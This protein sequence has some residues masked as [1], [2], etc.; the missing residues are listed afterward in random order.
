VEGSILGAKTDL[1]DR[2]ARLSV[3]GMKLC[4]RF[5]A[6][7]VMS[8]SKVQVTSNQSG[9]S[10]LGLTRLFSSLPTSVSKTATKAYFKTNAYLKLGANGT[11]SDQSLV[12]Q[13]EMKVK[14]LPALSDN[15]MYLIIDETSGE[16]AVVDP[17][18]PTTV[19]EAVKSSG[20]SLKSVLTTHHHWDH[21]GGNVKLNQLMPGLEFY[22]GDDRIDAL[23][24]KVGQGKKL[25]V[26]SLK[27]ECLFT[28]CHTQGHICYYVTHQDGSNP[29]VFTGDTLFLGGCGRFFEGTAEEMQEALN[30]TLAAL[31]GDTLVYCGHE[32]AIQNLKF[33]H[34]VE[35]DNKDITKALEEVKELR[36]ENKPS[37]PS[38]ISREKLINPFMRVSEASVKAAVNGTQYTDVE[39][40]RAVR[41]LKD[42][43]KP[44]K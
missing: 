16:A 7:Y 36:S 11:H 10:S 18:E 4:L 8:R 6:S 2:N 1:T 21:S 40:M 19:L 28:P 12:Q 29:A 32:Y 30:V 25:N 42:N 17:V 31:P 43:F 23:T 44:P 41:S 38:T 20:C 33:G 15:Y 26:G 37:V 3:K 34:H 13:N 27:V 24:S 35:P 22:G 14:I 5:S 9:T 39:T